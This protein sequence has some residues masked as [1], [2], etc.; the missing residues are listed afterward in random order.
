MIQL[1][2]G[3]FNRSLPHAS[4]A[5]RDFF[6][7]SFLYKWTGDIY[8]YS[9]G[10]VAPAPGSWQDKVIDFGIYVFLPLL[11]LFVLLG[12]IL[13]SRSADESRRNRIAQCQ[14]VWR[15]GNRF[16]CVDGAIARLRQGQLP[17]CTTKPCI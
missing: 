8:A 2:P 5:L 9:L 3:Q 1:R 10:A 6:E 17:L 7:S 15:G 12:L 11:F 4:D 16:R 14:V 13:V